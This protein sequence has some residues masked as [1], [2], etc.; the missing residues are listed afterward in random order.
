MATTLGKRKRRTAES[1]KEDR[2][3]SSEDSGSAEVDA[4]ELFRRH[5]EAKFKPLPVV[6]K[7]EKAAEEDSEDDS[8]EESN[9][10]GISEGGEVVEVVEH[11]DTQSRLALMSKEELKAFMVCQFLAIPWAILTLFPEL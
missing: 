9:W 7:V 5:F 8:E 3:D 11:T 10:D 4:Q 1:T 2:R 6:K